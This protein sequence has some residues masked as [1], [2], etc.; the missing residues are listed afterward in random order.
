MPRTP[1]GSNKYGSKTLLFNL[2]SDLLS[3]SSVL[4]GLRSGAAVRNCIGQP[5]LLRC[6]IPPRP[7]SCNCFAALKHL[8][9]SP[10]IPRRW[11]II[12]GPVERSTHVN[13]QQPFKWTSVHH[14]GPTVPFAPSPRGYTWKAPLNH[15]QLNVPS[16]ICTHIQPK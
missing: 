8:T 2:L 1:A 16:C 7:A 4:D 9:Q 15:N 10:R 13:Q 12:L 6:T 11:S 14:I 5:D 3:D